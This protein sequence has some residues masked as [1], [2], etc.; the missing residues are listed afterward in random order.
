MEKAFLCPFG[1]RDAPI[2]VKDVTIQKHEAFSKDK[3]RKYMKSQK[4][5]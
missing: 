5:L 4:K 3:K 2:N 1:L